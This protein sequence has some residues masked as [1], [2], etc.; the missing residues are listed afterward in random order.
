MRCIPSCRPYQDKDSK[1]NRHQP[2]LL[3][4]GLLNLEIIFS[5]LDFFSDLHLPI[6]RL[7]PELRVIFLMFTEI[8][9]PGNPSDLPCPKI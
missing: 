3:D 2:D 8:S 7:R 9:Q 4:P 1:E 6:V 5:G